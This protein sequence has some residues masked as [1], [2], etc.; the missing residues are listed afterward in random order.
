MWFHPNIFLVFIRL[1][2]SWTIGH[3][4]EDTILDL[5][6]SHKAR[7][8]GNRDKV[9]ISTSVVASDIIIS[10][11]LFFKDIFFRLFLE[12]IFTLFHLTHFSYN[13]KLGRH[14][15]CFPYLFDIYQ[16]LK[17]GFILE[18]SVNVSCFF[19]FLHS[20]FYDFLFH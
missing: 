1:S 12:V 9:T 8:I 17:L 15:K 3:H 5:S 20:K 16:F 7:N 2:S 18:L 6:T 13:P 11:Y 14:G 4:L 19:F 10:C